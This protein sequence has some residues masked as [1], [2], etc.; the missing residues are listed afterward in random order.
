ML[1]LRYIRENA[2]AVAE[3]CRN[4]GVSA[5]AV[6]GLKYQAG[7]QPPFS[8]AEI[9]LAI[10]F[11][12]VGGG[13]ARGLLDFDVAVDEW[14]AETLRQPTPDGPFARAHQPDEHDRSIKKVGQLLHDVATSIWPGLY[15]EA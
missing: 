10:A 2:D 12:Q 4:R 13:G 5:D 9:M 6:G 1:D 14:Q 3:N 15:I 7:D 11:E 8:I